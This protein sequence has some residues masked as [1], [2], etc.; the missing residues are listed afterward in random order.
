MGVDG[1]V[2]EENIGKLEYNSATSNLCF[3]K[4]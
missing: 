2:N 4:K 3:K 1:V